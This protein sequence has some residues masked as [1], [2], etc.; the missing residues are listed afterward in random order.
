MAESAVRDIVFISEGRNRPR[1]RNLGFGEAWHKTR[2]S[3]SS[4]AIYKSVRIGTYRPP[5]GSRYA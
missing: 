4:A 5:A 3:C 2:K 1:F